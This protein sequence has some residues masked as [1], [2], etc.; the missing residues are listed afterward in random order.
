[1]KNVILALIPLLL[2]PVFAAPST[3]D[4][5]IKK[6]V[7]DLFV[8]SKKINTPAEQKKA[9]A[10]IENSLDWDKISELCLGASRW[11]STSGANK[12]EFKRLLKEVILKTAYSRLDKFWTPDLTY[13]FQPI[14]WTGGNAGVPVKFTVKGEPFV[15]EYFF[16]KKAGKWTIFDV[17]YEDVRYSVNINEQLDA[18]L[19]EKGFSELLGK[20]RRRLEELDSPKK[21]S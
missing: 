4:A 18:F 5:V 2:S 8:A 13:E 17:S 12:T 1:M 16:T 14:T 9:R 6:Y 7:E 10:E 20:L 21:K 3:N 19:K 11:K 15:L